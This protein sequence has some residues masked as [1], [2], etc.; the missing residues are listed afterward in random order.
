MSSP[1]PKKED[2]SAA[3]LQPLRDFI[4]A[5]LRACS[6][7]VI[8]FDSGIRITSKSPIWEA[9]NILASSEFYGGFSANLHRRLILDEIR[10]Q[11]LR[12]AAGETQP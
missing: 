1:N 6:L 7:E 8:R 3:A 9:Q 12:Y 2:R 11:A 4:W 5:N 10:T